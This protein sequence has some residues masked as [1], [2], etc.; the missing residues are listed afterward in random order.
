M[1]VCGAKDASVGDV[2]KHQG[3]RWVVLEVLEMAFQGAAAREA[4]R[5]NTSSAPS[6]GPDTR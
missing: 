6:V 5:R 4:P 3:A 1:C 2:I